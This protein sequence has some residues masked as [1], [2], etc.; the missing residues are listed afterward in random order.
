MI[1]PLKESDTVGN[2]SAPFE[3]AQLVAKMRIPAQPRAAQF[4]K[5]V[6]MRWWWQR[7]QNCPR[8]RP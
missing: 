7:L 6:L 5:C 4:E 8:L 3:T 2:T 1:A